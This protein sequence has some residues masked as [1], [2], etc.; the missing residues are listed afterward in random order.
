ME[1]KAAGLLGGETL[2]ADMVSRYAGRK[3]IGWKDKGL[4]L[5]HVEF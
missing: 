2:S 1:T 4:G 5:G 3:G